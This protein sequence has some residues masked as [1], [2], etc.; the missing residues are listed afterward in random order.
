M[1]PN[2]T[3]PNQPQKLFDLVIIVGIEKRS[4]KLGDDGGHPIALVGHPPKPISACG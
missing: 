2:M 1:P 3:I 4:D